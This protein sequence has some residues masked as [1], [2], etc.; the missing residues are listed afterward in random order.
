MTPLDQEILNVLC[1]LNNFRHAYDADCGDTS[2]PTE[3]E[4]E[5]ASE[6]DDDGALPS[7]KF[8]ERVASAP[9]K[10]VRGEVMRDPS[11]FEGNSRCSIMRSDLSV[12]VAS[13]SRSMPNLYSNRSLYNKR[14]GRTIL[15]SGREINNHEGHYQ[16]KLRSA[17]FDRL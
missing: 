17:D 4:S 5:W 11:V 16:A 6:V 9:S 12:M 15:A 1:Q 7:P 10:L 3:L 13:N 14:L 8:C 2:D